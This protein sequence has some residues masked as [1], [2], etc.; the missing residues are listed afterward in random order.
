[1]RL[2]F[3]LGLSFSS[4]RVNISVSRRSLAFAGTRASVFTHSGVLYLSNAPAFNRAEIMVEAT[5]LTKSAWAHPSWS[6]GTK[7]HWERAGAGAVRFGSKGRRRPSERGHARPRYHYT[8]KGTRVSPSS[9]YG[10]NAG[11]APRR[12]PSPPDPSRGTLPSQ[13]CSAWEGSDVRRARRFCGASPTQ[14]ARLSD[15]DMLLGMA[16][17]LAAPIA[18][19]SHGMGGVTNGF[20]Q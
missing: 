16:Q 11:A 5:Y 9:P 19:S 10:R 6:C 12:A 20:T 17:L 13:V 15:L 14:V 2:T 3:D 18:A 8:L 1:V 7:V 4:T